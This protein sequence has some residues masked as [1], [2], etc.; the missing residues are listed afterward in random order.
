MKRLLANQTGYE[1]LYA[2]VKAVFRSILMFLWWST[3]AVVL[4][5]LGLWI[6]SSTDTRIGLR[7]KYDLDDSHVFMD[8]K[9]HDC[10]WAS[11]PLG[12]KHCHYEMVV[13]PQ[14]VY[15]GEEPVTFPDNLTVNNVKSVTVTWNKIQD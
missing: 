8:K 6:V 4:F 2:E 3:V 13:A 1:K 9:P 15:T 11:A 5:V 14:M 12:D 7:I 10:E